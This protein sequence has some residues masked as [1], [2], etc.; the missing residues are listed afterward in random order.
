MTERRARRTRPSNLAQQDDAD[1]ELFIEE[2]PEDDA[3]RP[4]RRE[5]HR[6]ARRAAPA[7]QRRAADDD[8][9]DDDNEDAAVSLGGGWG[10][11]RQRKAESSDYADDFRV[12]Y[13]EKYLIMFLDDEP[14]VSYVEHWI[15]E[16]PKGKKKSYVCLGKKNG[17]P[18][19]ATLGEKP[20]PRAM[21][22]ILEFIRTDAG[23]E[24]VHKVWTVGSGVA[25]EIEQNADDPGLLHNY[26]QVSKSQ[27]GKHGPTTYRVIPVDDRQLDTKW[28]MEPLTEEE[29]NKFMKAR[30]DKSY[31]RIPSKRALE[32]IAEEILA[33]D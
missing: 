20:S 22:N 16:M 15:D 29:I 30:Y 23:Y 11:W 25:S 4:A 32:E 7:V 26:F 14:F 1:D 10:S 13:K 27:A 31:V 6:P 19:C 17:C 5:S 28:D 3:A 2:D 8:E 12:D 24:P 9:D 21:F 33:L 18:L